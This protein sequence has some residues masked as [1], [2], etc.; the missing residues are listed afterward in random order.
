[1][2]LPLSEARVYGIYSVAL[3][4][5]KK[6]QWFSTAIIDKEDSII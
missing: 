2:I 1:M 3:I 5:P 4:N 6:K